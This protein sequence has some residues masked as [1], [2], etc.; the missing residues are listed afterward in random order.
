MVFC[1]L[2]RFDSFHVD[3]RS[4]ELFRSGV[5]VPIQDQ[6][7]QLLRLLLEAEG[8]VVTREQLRAALWAQGTF[9]DFEHAVNT[10]VKKLRQALED[11]AEHPKF[12]ETV[13]RIGYR[14]LCTPEWVSDLSNIHPLPRVVAIAP[15]GAATVPQKLPPGR[16]ALSGDKKQAAT[17]L[18]EDAV[19]PGTQ[20]EPLIRTRMLRYRILLAGMLLLAGVAFRAV[21]RTPS[22]PR[23][24]GF[25]QLTNDGQ[26]KGGALATD[27]SRIY[28]NETLI[29]QRSVIVQVPVTGGD[30]TPLSTP[31][32]QPRVLD[33]SRDGTELLIANDDGFDSSSLWVQP[34]V[35]GSPRRIVTVPI[36]DAKF[37]RDGKSIIYG[38]DHDVYS[39]NRDGSSGRKLLTAKAVP[40]GFRFSPGGRT[41]RFTELDQRL[42]S[43]TIMQAAADGTSL[44]GIGGRCCGEW[45]SDARFFIFQ[46]RS[47]P[48]L[49]RIDLW[50]LP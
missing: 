3:L 46:N 41:F 28:F 21:I 16:E 49:L 7:L 13:P 48:A 19:A 23:V 12:V 31:L 34:V 40:F 20:R 1:T 22:V 44:H 30:A 36:T 35:G 43:M 37:G 15:P 11:S 39:V 33:L 14:F 18:P 6:P 8:R 25:T 38:T 29:D 10:A 17:P 50:A 45:T 26:G 5:R 27:G 42:D 2:V 47:D 9:V 32:K 24:L 4:G